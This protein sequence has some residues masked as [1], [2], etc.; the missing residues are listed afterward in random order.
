MRRTILL[1]AA[2]LL[3]LAGFGILLYPNVEGLLAGHENRERIE[4]FREERGGPDTE[5]AAYADLLREMQEY[6]G[7]ISRDGQKDLKDVWSYEQNPFDFRAAGLPDDM[8]GYITI[9]AMDVE[10]PLYIGANEENMK[11]GAVVM[12]QT[13]M[14]VGGADTNCVVAAHRGYQ[15][16]PMFRNIEA[17]E[18][19]DRVEVT[20]LWE[21]LEYEVVRSIVI[22]PDDIDAVKIIPGEELLTLITCH[23]YTQN[24]QRYVVYC[25]RA[26]SA[27]MNGADQNSVQG[28]D[29]LL[30][31][32]GEA[33][34][35]SGDDI[36]MERLVNFTALG[37]LTVLAA[38]G[39][40]L[41]CFRRKKSGRRGRRQ[42]KKTDRSG[43]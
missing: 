4:H 43:H 18:T 11:K 24:Y 31:I 30:S 23:P 40:I 22:D 20:N 35:S 41:L 3:F 37:L 16:I 13:S 19:G 25:R 8:I 39:L 5:Q 36:R 14:P 32:T 17:L 12:G 21:T 28:G 9:E 27:E 7:Q 29:P 6:N 26:G 10:M 42:R 2:G 1:I 34:E 33:F 15:G 38:V